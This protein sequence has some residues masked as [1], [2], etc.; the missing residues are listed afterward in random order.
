MNDR[1]ACCTRALCRWDAPFSAEYLAQHPADRFE[2]LLA[3]ADAQAA[4]ARATKAEP[5]F[6]RP[7]APLSRVE[8]ILVSILASAGCPVPF[9]LIRRALSKALGEL[10]GRPLPRVR[11]YDRALLSLLCERKALFRSVDCPFSEGHAELMTSN[12]CWWELAPGV[13]PHVKE[14]VDFELQELRYIPVL[15]P[16]SQVEGMAPVLAD[17]AVTDQDIARAREVLA[18]AAAQGQQKQSGKKRGNNNSGATIALQQAP[19]TAATAAATTST[20]AAATSTS[21]AATASAS[22]TATAAE[23]KNGKQGLAAAPQTRAPAK[24]A[25]EAAQPA[26]VTVTLSLTQAQAPPQAPAPAPAEQPVVVKIE[27]HAAEPAACVK[28]TVASASAAEADKCTKTEPADQQGTKEHTK[29]CTSS[30]PAQSSGQADAAGAGTDAAK[31]AQDEGAAATS[32]VLCTFCEMEIKPNSKRYKYRDYGVDSSGTRNECIGG[33]PCMIGERRIATSDFVCAECYKHNEQLYRRPEL[34]TQQ[35]ARRPRL[36][37]SGKPE[38]LLDG[39]ASP[40]GGPASSSAAAAEAGD[41]AGEKT[42]LSASIPVPAAPTERQLEQ[43]RILVAAALNRASRPQTEAQLARYVDKLL[44]HF[45]WAL[46]EV[47]VVPTRK[48]HPRSVRTATAVRA[49]LHSSSAALGFEEVPPSSSSGAQAWLLGDLAALPSAHTA[50]TA[51]T[52]AAGAKAD[53]HEQES[54]EENEAEGSSSDGEGD[55]D[56]S[57]DDESGQSDSA[58]EETGAAVAPVSA[59]EPLTMRRRKST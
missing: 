19:A 42:L 17:V 23:A 4:A 36:A 3:A 10:Q 51:T 7:E 6:A 59:T 58:D 50:S 38:Q 21:T 46:T 16:L 12:T 52:T 25:A 13:L 56:D 8:Q 43:M 15:P 22:S 37:A 57:E 20:T 41:G 55:E 26:A 18:G 33:R 40:A 5:P 48:R 34:V 32:P 24:K 53:G 27:C 49:A 1:F 45:N 14:L 39:T 44:G 54:D 47:G 11:A 28:V 9:P 2:Q 35:S 29:A 31:A 30:T